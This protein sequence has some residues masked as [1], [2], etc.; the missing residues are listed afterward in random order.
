MENV[1]C[2]NNETKLFENWLLE[3]KG[4]KKGTNI[5]HL[6]KTCDKSK[7]QEF[8]HKQLTVALRVRQ[9]IFL[10]QFL[11]RYVGLLQ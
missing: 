9:L 3:I 7:T 2:S 11:P 8:E 6:E 5:A 4:R 1:T 10:C